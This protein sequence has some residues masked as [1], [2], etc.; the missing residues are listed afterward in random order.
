MK[1]NKILAI[2][3]SML[4]EAAIGAVAQEASFHGYMDYTTFG[5]GQQVGNTLNG[6][7]EWTYTDPA[8]EYGSFYNGRTELN[9]FFS[10]ANLAFNVGVRLDTSLGEWYECYKDSSDQFDPART[11][12]MFH[13]ANMRATFWQDQIILFAGKF[14][15]WNDGFLYG[16]WALG[17]QPMHHLGFRGTGQHFTGIEWVPNMSVFG[18][19]LTG[20]R[21]IVGAPFL[22]PSG[23]YDWQEANGDWMIL[24]KIKIMAQYKWLKP[25]I[26]FNVG[27]RPGTYYDGLKES[28]LCYTL[29]HE[30][31]YTHNF[32]SAA[33]AQVDLPTTVPGFKFNASYEIRW[34]E[35][36]YEGAEGVTNVHAVS[37]YFGVSGHTELVPGWVFNFENRIYYAGD[38]YI[39]VNEKAFFEQLGLNAMHKIPGTPYNIG[40]NFNGQIGCDAR[41]TAFNDNGRIGD[42]GYSCDFSFCSEWMQTACMPQAGD[43]GHYYGAYLY[44]FFQKDFANGFFRTGVEMQYT[45]FKSVT[46]AQ[47]FNYRVPFALCFWY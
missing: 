22:P 17:D 31:N 37:H 12:T 2:S 21:I 35:D 4:V 13:Q 18:G 19:A 23:D 6:G 16:G 11:E 34:R 24:K 44:P 27:I 25:N 33:Y 39:R 9:C 42:G 38:H 41:G 15:E 5:I 14:E 1:R 32:F 7:G 29:A 10:A 20:F 3:A 45:Y 43:K 40:I 28:D 30:S 8:A 36:D 47:A 26:T 46:S